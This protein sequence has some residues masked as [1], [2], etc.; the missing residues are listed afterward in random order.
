MVTTLLGPHSSER[1][2]GD[3]DGTERAVC[4]PGA[5]GHVKTA[6]RALLMFTLGLGVIAPL[7]MTGIARVAFPQ[8]AEGS[9]IVQGGQVVGSALIGQAVDPAMQ[10]YYFQNRPSALA[11][12]YDAATSGGANLAQTSQKQRDAVATR[13]AAI[14]SA[15]PGATTVP[16]DLVMASGSGLDPDITPE[17]ARRQVAAIARNRANLGQPVTPAA[18]QQ[19]VD[20]Q[21]EGRTF[22]ILGQPRVNVLRLNLA[23]DAQFGKP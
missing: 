9:L 8:Q 23:L 17:A 18:V 16:A 14:Q 19:L 22:G 1:S 3:A 7:A 4:S 2:A 10:P 6:L 21:T 20:R 11:T 5:A 12:P 13:A 15:A